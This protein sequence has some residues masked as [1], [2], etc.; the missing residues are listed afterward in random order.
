MAEKR[1]A[2]VVALGATIAARRR[3]KGLTQAQLAAFIGVSQ[4]TMCQIE[5]GEVATQIHRLQDFANHLTC[6]VPDLFRA[7]SPTTG[8]AGDA[9]RINDLLCLLPPAYRKVILSLVENAVFSLKELVEQEGAASD[10]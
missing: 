7:P 8:P 6:S 2:L 3:A 10:G 5:N 4:T 1:C 9:Q